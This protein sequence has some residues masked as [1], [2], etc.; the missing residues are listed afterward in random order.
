METPGQAPQG[1]AEQTVVNGYSVMVADPN[2]WWAGARGRHGNLHALDVQ[3]WFYN[4]RE[5]VRCR[6]QSWFDS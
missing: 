1:W 4:I 3:F 5:N 6:L 2:G